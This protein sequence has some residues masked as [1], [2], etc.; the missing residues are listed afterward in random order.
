LCPLWKPIHSFSLSKTFE[1]LTYF[2]KYIL[3]GCSSGMDYAHIC[4][5]QMAIKAAAAAS[6]PGIDTQKVSNA[7]MTISHVTSLQ[8]MSCC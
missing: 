5:H 2:T 1:K 8:I 3:L 7:I 6:A 4:T